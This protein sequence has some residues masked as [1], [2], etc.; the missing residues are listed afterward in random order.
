[1]DSSFYKHHHFTFFWGGEFSQWFPSKFT[2]LGLTFNC[3]E[4]FMMYYKALVFEDYLRAQKI[5]RLSDPDLIKQQ[6]RAILNFTEEKWNTCRLKIVYTGNELKF[7]QNPDLKQKLLNTRGTYL[8]EASPYDKIWG[9]GLKATNPLINDPKNWRG[10]NLLGL[11][12]TKL[13]D[14]LDAKH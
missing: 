13:R 10:Q 12:L 3:C 9:V 14:N 8:V 11:I 6:G 5:M 1:M 4:Q 2:H 7:T